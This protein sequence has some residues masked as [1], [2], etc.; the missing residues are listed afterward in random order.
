M[1]VDDLLCRAILYPRAWPADVFDVESLLQFSSGVEKNSYVLSIASRFILG[2]ELDAHRYGCRAAVAGNARFEE[3]NQRKPNPVREAVHYL[4]FYDMKFGEVAK[5]SLDHYDIAVR[6]RYENG[7]NA[8]F[9]VE[10]DPKGGP[11]SDRQRRNDRTVARGL[12]ALCLIGPTRHICGCDE[13]F[14]IELEAIVVPE[15]PSAVDPKIGSS[16]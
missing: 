13:A 10:M 14:R 2:S 7:E 9:Q 1:L 5:I 16:V 11:A 4:G 3:K 12:L 6:W 15:M 8:H